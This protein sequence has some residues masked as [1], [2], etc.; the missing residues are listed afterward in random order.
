MTDPTPLVAVTTGFEATEQLPTADG[1]LGVFAALGLGPATVL[2][3]A[4]RAELPERSARVLADALVGLG[5]LEHVDGRYRNT[6][7]SEACLARP[8]PR[9]CRTPSDAPDHP[10]RAD[11]A[12]RGPTVPD[13]SRATGG[14]DRAAGGQPA[15]ALP[16]TGAGLPC[17]AAGPLAGGPRL[18]IAEAV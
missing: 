11:A 16:P 12:R 4:E 2:E 17:P 13:G 3:L 5:L 1:G 15:R 6:P 10:R 14:R 9:T 18:V 8:V 7:V